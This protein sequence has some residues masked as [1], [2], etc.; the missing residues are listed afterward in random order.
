MDT[1]TAS[2]PSHVVTA[3]R[4]PVASG[5]ADRMVTVTATYEL[6][7]DGRKMCL[8]AGGDGRAVQK[9]TMDVP[10]S[11]LHLVTVDSEGVARLKLRPLYHLDAL[12]RVMRVDRP[13]TYDAPPTNDDLLKEAARN[14][15]LERAYFGERTASRTKRREASRELRD[16]IAQQFLNDRTQRALPHPDP[17]PTRCCVGAPE[18]RIRFDVNLDD[19]T[20]R[21]VPP[22]AHRRFRADLRARAERRQQERAAQL[23]VFEE[24]KRVAAE[25]IATRGTAEQQARHAAGV[26]PIAE[27]VDLMTEEIFRPLSRWPIYPLDGAERLQAHLRQFTKSAQATVTPQDL[28]ITVADAKTASSAQWALVQELQK[29]LPDAAVTI[30]AHRLAWKRRSTGDH[31]VRGPSKVQAGPLRIVPRICSAS[32]VRTQTIRE[33]DRAFSTRRSYA[34][35][36]D[37]SS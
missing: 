35:S 37:V 30:R 14:H 31:G 10:A 15:Q 11:R 2:A 6:S 9:V 1:A 36:D 8:L 4:T 20:A 25:W 3:M 16:R 12:Q 21:Q 19:G 34:P 33:A 26:L 27:A 7:E 18:G 5:D 24:K 32:C 29:A 23:A 22:E 17:T 28:A 13:P